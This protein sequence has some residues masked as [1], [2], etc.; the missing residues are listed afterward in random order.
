MLQGSTKGPSGDWG[1]API[2]R[3]GIIIVAVILLFG[4]IF[5]GGLYAALVTMRDRQGAAPPPRSDAGPG[6]SSA[7]YSIAPPLSARTPHGRHGTNAR[8]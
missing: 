5:L 3:R 2:S 4:A 6:R 7:T 1:D 8:S